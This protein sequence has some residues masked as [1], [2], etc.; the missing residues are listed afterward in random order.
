MSNLDFK[1]IEFWEHEYLEQIFYLLT[2][3]KQKILNG[4]NT[5][6]DI[7]SDWKE[8]IGKETL[9]F[10][11]GSKR[12]F[13]WLFNQFGVPNS[14]PIGSDMFFE[15]YNAFVHIDIK[16][17]TKSNIEDIRNNIFVGIIKIVIVVL[18]QLILIQMN[19]KVIC[20]HFTLN[21]MA[22]KSYA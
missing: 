7:K 16:T 4:F 5:K 18:F 6:E 20:L 15:T 1:K 21:L 10:A 9:D 19:I 2:I 17:I 13:Y 12:I 11:T 14:S 22:V 3:S 8:F